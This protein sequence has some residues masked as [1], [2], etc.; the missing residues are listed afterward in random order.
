MCSKPSSLAELPELSQDWRSVFLG[1]D[2]RN[3]MG[4][5]EQVAVG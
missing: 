3:D 4:L 2:W 1:F 5:A